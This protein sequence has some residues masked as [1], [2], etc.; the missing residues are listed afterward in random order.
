MQSRGRSPGLGLPILACLVLCCGVAGTAAC[1]SDGSGASDD[2]DASSAFDSG[3]GSDGTSGADGGG[4]SDGSHA[5]ARADSGIDASVD[6]GH[7]PNPVSNENGLP[8]TLEW[9]L[10]NPATQREIEGYPSTTSVAPGGK[11]SL[12]VSTASARY[13]ID[14][15]RLG[16]YAGKGGRQEQPQIERDGTLQTTPVPD[17]DGLVECDWTDPYELTIPAS[18]VSGIYV[19]KLT[20]KGTGKQAYV[21]FVVRDDARVATY[22]VQSSVTTFQAYNNWGGRS[23]YDFNSAGGVRASRVSLHRP[24]GLGLNPQSAAGIGAGELITNLQGAAQTGPTGW[25]Y[26]MVRFLEREGYD[27]SYVTNVDVHR[28]ALLVA[29]H[30]VFL[31]VGHDEYWSS[32][33]RDHVEHARDHGN[34]SLAFFSGNVSYWQIRLD[35]AKTGTPDTTITCFKDGATDPTASTPDAHLTTVRFDN[36]LL[37]R[38]EE[39]L[40]GLA[41]QDFGVNSALVVLEPKSW[42]FGATGLAAGA[43][44]PGLLGYEVDGTREPPVPGVRRV[45]RS[46]WTTAQPSSGASEAAVRALPS[47]AETFAAGSIQF[48]WGLDDHRSPGVVQPVVVSAAAQQIARN[49]LDRFGAPRPPRNRSSLLLDEP[50]TGPLDPER[51]SLR[52]VNEGAAAYDP[53]VT[54][55]ATGGHLVI[56]PRSGVSGLHHGGATTA[57]TYA[58]T[59]GSARVELVQ[60]ASAASSADTTFAMVADAGRFYRMTVEAGALVFGTTAGAQTS[61]AYDAVAHRHLRI[62]HDCVADQILYETSPDAVTWTTRRTIAAA[63]D[64]RSAYIELEAGTFQ[65]EA[66]PGQ[67]I[68]DNLRVEV[69]GV[70]ESFASQRDPELF[71]PT[72]LHEGGYDP[73]MEVFTGG[74]ALHLRPRGGISNLHH[75][76]FAT[77]REIEW[78]GGIASVAVLQA[79]NTATEASV[80]LAVLAQ[81]PGWARAT[82]SAGNVYFQ[83]ENAGVSTSMFIPYDPIAHK[84]LRIRHDA[85]ADQVVWETSPDSATWTEQRRVARPFLLAAVRAEIEGGTYRVETDPGEAIIDDFV[86]AK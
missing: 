42:V 85:V 84:Y 9:A 86:F 59:C 65:S 19:A 8:G 45:M 34:T 20:T 1:G 36:P 33:M 60:A 7:P 43:Q 53:A 51:W 16:W 82:V 67:A 57:R 10:T 50:F 14:V 56:T 35:P 32:R 44:L 55:A 28:D 29:Q 71:T 13:T 72:S 41:L 76:G 11:I 2:A 52:T 47:G 4:G 54:V 30:P 62:R 40:A 37:A 26:P 17:A 31:S 69:S 68:F 58:L 70:R 64:L 24:Y 48:A 66:A 12:F 18:W 22:L 21:P 25:E 74:G 73:E 3:A 79:P 5:D 46:P 80:T 63:V 49:V 83:S 23:L 78:T 77:T 38:G 6:G 39:G 27:V 15:Y 61:I 81:T 75:L